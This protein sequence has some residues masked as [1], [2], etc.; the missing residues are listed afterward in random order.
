[1][2]LEQ[3]AESTKEAI[4]KGVPTTARQCPKNCY[5]WLIMSI[6]NVMDFKRGKVPIA[7]GKKGVASAPSTFVQNLEL[8]FYYAC[9][10]IVGMLK[11]RDGTFGALETAPNAIEVV[12][13]NYTA[14]PKVPAGATPSPRPPNTGLVPTDPIFG[15]SVPKWCLPGHKPFHWQRGAERGALGGESGCSDCVGRSEVDIENPSSGGGE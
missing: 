14:P 2:C 6:P 9:F 4:G 5:L 11:R 3:A 12:Y 7:A 8:H 10:P 13:A 15:P 1:M